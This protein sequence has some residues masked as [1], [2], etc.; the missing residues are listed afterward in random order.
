MKK[1]FLLLSIMSC[2]LYLTNALASEK[3]PRWQMNC[4]DANYGR[5]PAKLYAIGSSVAV[6]VV[7]GY[8]TAELICSFNGPCTGIRFG[9]QI[10]PEGTAH[11]NRG[12][13]GHVLGFSY[14]SAI[15]LYNFRCQ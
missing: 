5:Y 12:S 14:K 4:K 3:D 7:V 11:L 10:L 2:S 13:N 9:S 1:I 15:G 8:E 6:S